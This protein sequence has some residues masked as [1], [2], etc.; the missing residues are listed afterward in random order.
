MLSPLPQ[1]AREVLSQPRLHRAVGV[2]Y[3][4]QTELQS[5]YCEVVLPAW[6]DGVVFVDTTNP[7]VEFGR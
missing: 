7:V 1:A 5:H 6:A 2:V 3:K 4:P